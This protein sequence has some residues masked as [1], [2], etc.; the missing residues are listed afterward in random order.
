M[1]EV[2]VFKLACELGFD[3][4]GAELNNNIHSLII[5]NENCD[6]IPGFDSNKVIAYNCR[7]N[8]DIKRNSVAMHLKEYIELKAE[9]KNVYLVKI[10]E[11]L[12]TKI[13]IN[14]LAE[15]CLVKGLIKRKKDIKR[16]YKKM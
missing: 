15:E 2:D 6:K 14:F 13:N 3:V 16:L 4:R 11:E 7:K 10:N 8:I 9:Q 1:N 5:V 12:Y